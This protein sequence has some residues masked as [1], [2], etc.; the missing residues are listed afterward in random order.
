MATWDDVRRLAA[1]LPGTDVDP[2]YGGRPS[3]RVAGRAFVWDRPSTGADREHLDDTAPAEDE[4][5]LGVRVADESVER[6]LLADEP[7]AV[8]TTP[9]FDGYP[10]VLVRRLACVSHDLLAELVED[11]WRA[12]A[13]R[14]LVVEL[15]A[16]AGD[17]SGP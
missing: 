4:A 17:R 16:R 13:P 3:W 15:D 6:A 9:H 2:S 14:R 5:L 8:L 12:R 1:A 7:D 11:A 10:V